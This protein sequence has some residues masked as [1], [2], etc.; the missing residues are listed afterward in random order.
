MPAKTTLYR[1]RCHWVLLVV[2][3]LLPQVS[4]GPRSDDSGELR[5]TAADSV[6]GALLTAHL[7]AN[8]DDLHDVSMRFHHMDH[9]I[10]GTI[11]FAMSWENGVLTLVEV[12][13]N[14]TDNADL[15]A[16]LIEKFRSWRIEGLAGPFRTNLP[17]NIRL[18][19][20]DDPAFPATA[21]VTGTVTDAGGQPLHGAEVRFIARRPGQEPVLAARTNRE[22]VFVR[23]LIPPGE[24]S[25][26][27]THDGWAPVIIEGI[28]LAPGQH[29]R[30]SIVLNRPDPAER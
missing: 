18:V 12:A 9:T 5:G 7:R 4:C 21:I 15:A 26:Q 11:A 27:C 24:W 16:A 8:F 28:A 2:L 14:E 29:H 1:G 3:V 19:G 10:G 30:E 17:I 20:S 25:L 13:H 22:G 6:A 23:T